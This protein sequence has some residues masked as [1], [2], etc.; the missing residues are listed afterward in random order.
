MQ[1]V[2]LAGKSEADTGAVG[3][4]NPNSVRREKAAPSGSDSARKQPAD[5][6]PALWRKL[7]RRRSGKSG[8]NPGRCRWAGASTQPQGGGVRNDRSGAAAR[9]AFR[10]RL[11][12]DRREG[13]IL[14]AG[15]AKARLR[16]EARAEQIERSARTREPG[17]PVHGM[18]VNTIV[19]DAVGLR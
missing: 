1:G 19:S 15:R 8:S 14:H 17:T 2:I 11:C 6:A 5:L 9:L 7:Q 10:R 12:N 18:S 16:G 13:A 3:A 4:L